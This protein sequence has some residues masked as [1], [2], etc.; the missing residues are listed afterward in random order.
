MPA[1]DGDGDGLFAG[2]ATGLAR[3]A[4]ECS[5]IGGEEAVP[6]AGGEGFVQGGRALEVHV[7][8]LDVAV[9]LKEEGVTEFV[10]GGSAEAIDELGGRHSG[11]YIDCDS[12]GDDLTVRGE[13]GDLGETEGSASAR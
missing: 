1:I 11:P 8:G 5:A 7:V 9:T 4:V 3:S 2:D 12:G 6:V 10:G 13:E